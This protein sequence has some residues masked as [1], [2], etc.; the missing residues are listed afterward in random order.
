MARRSLRL[1]SEPLEEFRR[2][3]VRRLQPIVDPEVMFGVIREIRLLDRRLALPR[4]VPE[5][6]WYKSRPV[7]ERMT[8]LLE[9]THFQEELLPEFVAGDRRHMWACLIKFDIQGLKWLNEHVGEASADKVIRWVARCLRQARKH[10]RPGFEYFSARTGGDEFSVLVAGLPRPLDG[11][12]ITGRIRDQ[13]EVVDTAR[14]DEKLRDF[15]L[16]MHNGVTSLLMG[17]L[18]TRQSV[19]VAASI[20]MH[21]REETD[22]KLRTSKHDRARNIY[23]QAFEMQGK[24]I[25]PI[26]VESRLLIEI[27][28]E[29]QP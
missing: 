1:L 4:H 20:A 6:Y 9:K 21:W 17:P 3:I 22:S 19:K 8:G 15:K 11:F 27:Q 16:L 14:L 28:E 18:E 25:V 5:I 7:Y 10:V 23:F 2:R 24:S 29:L 26:E 12:M 13:I